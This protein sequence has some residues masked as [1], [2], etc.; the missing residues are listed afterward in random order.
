MFQFSKLALDAIIEPNAD[1]PG[2]IGFLPVIL[3]NIYSRL[4]SEHLN[5]S[6]VEPIVQRL[7]LQAA[8]HAIRPLCLFEMTA[9]LQTAYPSLGL[10]LKT[11]KGIIRRSS[12]P[13]LETLPD[14]TVSVLFPSFTEYLDGT[15]KLLEDHGV[16]DLDSDTTHLH[17][18]RICMDYLGH[19]LDEEWAQKQ[20]MPG[21]LTANSEDLIAQTAAL[22][23]KY[24]LFEYVATNWAVH[25]GRTS[26]HTQ[27]SV[28]D[29][30]HALFQ[31]PLFRTEDVQALVALRQVS[32]T[33]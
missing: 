23:L 17:L 2:A 18:A 15:T 4:L 10:S 5:K 1:V 9:L 25:L 3:D 28:N 30:D 29:K 31:K 11:L 13:L 32:R 20:E 22:M 27:E 19:L 7:I 8:T 16:P 24:P 14:D 26:I 6:A 33:S 12:G 21:D